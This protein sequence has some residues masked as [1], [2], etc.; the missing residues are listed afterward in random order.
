M[1]M[2]TEPI[3]VRSCR[4]LAEA[5]AELCACDVPHRAVVAGA[6]DADSLLTALRSA[7]IQDLE[8]CSLFKPCDDHDEG[9]HVNFALTLTLTLP[10]PSRQNQP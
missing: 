3:R 2:C 6:A 5:S 4:V 10:Y 9:S 1:T 8:V 7:G